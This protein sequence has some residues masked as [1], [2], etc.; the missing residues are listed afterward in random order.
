[1]GTSPRHSQAN[2]FQSSKHFLS[3]DCLRRVRGHQKLKLVA[4][5]L[6]EGDLKCSW[7]LAELITL[8][9][10]LPHAF[11]LKAMLVDLGG[12]LGLSE[13]PPYLVRSLQP[14]ESFEAR[15]PGPRPSVRGGNVGAGQC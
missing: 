8:P 7:R 6:G 5:P 14:H 2:V 15:W 13:L 10:P 3:F 12:P 11:S 1:M 9:W 4:L